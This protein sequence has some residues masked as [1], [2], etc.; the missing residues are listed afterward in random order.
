MSPTLTPNG[1]YFTNKLNRIA[2]AAFDLAERVQI[3]GATERDLA[4]AVE[5]NQQYVD[6]LD[7][8]LDCKLEP[9]P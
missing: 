8:M 1:P 9:L 7:E 2:R 3:D 6:V 4:M 5:L